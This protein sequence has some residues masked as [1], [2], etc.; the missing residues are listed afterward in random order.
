MIGKKRSERR[1]IQRIYK[2]HQE[3]ILQYWDDLTEKEQKH[4]LEIAGA[5]NFRKIQK[6]YKIAQTE[7]KPINFS[8]LEPSDYI[9]STDERNERFCQLGINALKTGKVA[10]LTVAGGQASRLGI[11]LPKGCFGISPITQKSLFQIFAEKILFYSKLYNQPLK[12]FIM[13]SVDNYNTTVDFFIQNNYFNLD[14]ENI[15][16]FKQGIN[17]TVTSESGDLILKTK[18]ELFMN[19]NGHGGILG[20]L[21][22]QGYISKMEHL[23]IEYLSYFQVDNPLINMADPCFIGC[24]IDEN[25]NISTKIIHKNFAEEK[26][27]VPMQECKS[28]KRK[29]VEYSDI[30]KEIM[31]QKDK[32]GSLLF[33]MGSTGIHIFS[34]S[35]IKKFSNKLPIHI[36]NKEIMVTDFNSTDNIEKSVSVLKFETFV[37]DTIPLAKKSIFFETSRN[38]EF[39]PLK[40]KTGVDSIETCTAG[41]T[42]LFRSWLKEIGFNDVDK[43]EKCEISPLFA[44]DRTNFLEAAKNKLSN[45]KEM[46]YENGNIKKEIYIH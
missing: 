7:N 39:L 17:P 14:K 24:H 20:A 2:Y 27:G 4:L 21:T 33:N 9:S 46:V 11:D 32:N 44:P 16:F 41:Q 36:A 34:V 18:S 8:S 29:I 1:S 37:F 10:F 26:L 43:I 3:H 25:S 42:E 5:I 22:S 45:I 19:P 30:P 23:G 15:F 13:T 31:Q 40:N 6:Y 35:F 38:E 28:T 12:W